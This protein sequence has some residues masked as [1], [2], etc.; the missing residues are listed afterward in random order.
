[1]TGSSLEL[2]AEQQF[3]SKN[4]SQNSRLVGFGDAHEFL[5]GLRVVDISVRVILETELAILFLDD[6]VTG[7]L[8]VAK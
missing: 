7:T 5:F 4:S 1:M 3:S 2:A 8:C 6:S